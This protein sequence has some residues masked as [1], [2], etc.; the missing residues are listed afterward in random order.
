INRYFSGKKKFSFSLIIILSLLFTALFASLLGT[1]SRGPALGAFFAILI[2]I[3]YGAAFLRGLIRRS[4]SGIKGFYASNRHMINTFLIIIGASLIVLSALGATDKGKASIERLSSS[5]ADIPG[6]LKQSRLHIWIPALKMIKEHP[7]VGTGTDTFKAVFP[8]YEGIEFAQIDGVNVS[9]RTA[10]NELL[11]IPATMGIISLGLYLL[12]IFSYILLWKKSFSKLDNFTDKIL[13]L[14]IFAGFTAYF[15]QNLF[16]FGVAAINTIFYLFMAM[17]VFEYM[18]SKK[19]KIYRFLIPVRKTH[20]KYLLY[21]A[22]AALTVFFAYKAHSVLTA[23]KHYNRGTLLGALHNRWDLAVLE[24]E[25]AV[26]LAPNEVKYRVYLGLAFERYALSSEKGPAHQKE[27]IEK[28]ALNYTRGVELNPLN[29]YYWGN[30]GRVHT[31]LAQLSREYKYYEKAVDFYKK[32]IQMAPVTGLFYNNLLEAY[33]RMGL[34]KEAES[35]LEKVEA[36]DRKLAAT[37]AFILGNGYFN[38]YGSSGDS[39]HLLKSSELYKKSISINPDFIQGIFNYGV[40][41]ASLGDTF[42]AAASMEKVLSLDPEFD[43]RN[44]AIRIIN[45][46]KQAR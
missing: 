27:L 32:A 44:E 15:I 35:L 5:V 46:M 23:D 39:A 43:N 6:S 34:I 1:Q 14:G 28:A 30:L 31:L 36:Y 25:K 13:S 38:L 12:L 2:F 17:H 29:A 40:T 10:H 11:H 20:T 45:D 41:A 19:T 9:S 7:F 8:R 22:A 33:A 42:N 26:K 16:S 4:P 18:E 21:A 37:S 24:H 3:A